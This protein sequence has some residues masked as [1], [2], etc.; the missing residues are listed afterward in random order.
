V[1]CAS[2]SRSTHSAHQK[3]SVGAWAMSGTN[4]SIARFTAVPIAPEELSMCSRADNTLSKKQHRAFGGLNRTCP[5]DSS[6]LGHRFSARVESSVANT[7]PKAFASK[8][9]KVKSFCPLARSR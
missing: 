7:G 6:G 3:C 5:A 2:H 9:E 1:V 8:R 4:S